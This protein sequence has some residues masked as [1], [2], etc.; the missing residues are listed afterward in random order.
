MHDLSLMEPLMPLLAFHRRAERQLAQLGTLAMELR[1]RRL[2]PDL[3][4]AAAAALRTLGVERVEHHALEEARFLPSLERRL[5]DRQAVEEFRRMRAWIGDDHTRV[6]EC[7]RALRRPLEAIAE[8]VPRAIDFEAVAR[9]RTVYG[10]HI[11]D[12]ETALHRFAL[13][14]LRS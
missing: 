8:G 1:A 3:C 5:R 6:G 2:A 11:V 9:L 7:W 13:R 14:H 12:E 4:A 10:R